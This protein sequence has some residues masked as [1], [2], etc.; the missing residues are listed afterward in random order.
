MSVCAHEYRQHLSASANTCFNRSEQFMFMLKS[1]ARHPVNSS[2][3]QL[4]FRLRLMLP[5][6]GSCLSTFFFVLSVI[7]FY[8]YLSWFC[9]LPSA[10][11]FT[12]EIHRCESLKLPA[13]FW[14][15]VR[16]IWIPYSVMLCTVQPIGTH[17]LTRCQCFYPC[18]NL[19]SYQFSMTLWAVLHRS[20]NRSF[21]KEYRYLIS[22]KFCVHS[23]ALNTP[24][25]LACFH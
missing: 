8:L 9:A 22:C 1:T 18:F 23:R 10:L 4:S 15:S 3:Q 5:C 17:P 25:L 2:V 12:R 16:C 20:F 19:V 7:Y 13:L 6:N 24:K 11:E 14:L 21:A